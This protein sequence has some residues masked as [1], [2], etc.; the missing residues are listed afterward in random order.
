MRGFTVGFSASLAA[1]LWL[2][3]NLAVAVAV[4][5]WICLVIL[6]FLSKRH[7]WL[8]V[9]LCAGGALAHAIVYQQFKLQLPSDSVRTDLT[10]VGTV[11]SVP[12]HDARQTSFLFRIDEVLDPSVNSW[13]EQ[14]RLSWYGGQR[15]S[16][17]AGDRWQLL[18]RL[19]PSASLGNPGGFNFEQWLFYNKIH[20]TGY[21]RDS[22][23]PKQLNTNS[24]SLHAIRESLAK[25]IAQ[26]PSANEYAAL[27]QGLTVG[28]TS[29]ISIEQWQ[30]LRQSGTAHL[31]AISGLH[32][33]LVS[34]WF[35]FFA[36][37]VW[38]F[39]HIN[40]YLSRRQWCIKPVFS[41]TLSC[42]SA[43]AYAALAGFSLPTQ[44]ALIML[45]VFALTV[46]L[47]RIWPPGTAM[48]LALLAVLL[49]GPLAVLSVGF[50]LSF[51]T[52]AALFYLHNGRISRIGSKSSAIFVHLKLG[53]V[54]L[55]VTA[56]FF[57]QGSLVAPVANAIA[58]PLVGLLVVPVSLVIALITPL[59]SAGAN[60]LLSM[61]QW[62]LAKLL[63]LLDRML[64]L[65]ASHLPLFLPDS[66]VLLCALL[67]LLLLFSPRSLRLRWL[68]VPLLAPAVVL[69]VLGKPVRGIDLHVLDV[70]QGLSA[71]L[72]T[73]NHT[74]LFDTGK[75]ISEN[76]T[77]IDRVV[78]PFLISQGRSSIDIS[79][80][81]HADDDH[82][83]GVESL[84]AYY[85]DTRLFAG[86]K[87]QELGVN[88]EACIA[89][90]TFVFD[91]VTFTFIHPGASDMGS[92]NNMSCVL[93]V[94]YGNTRILLTGDIESESERLLVDRIGQQLP[95]TTLIAPHH[96]SRSSST[97]P[98]V[99]IF[100]ADVVVFA[101]GENNKF[102]FPHADVVAR[103]SRTG[104]KLFTT[105]EH[106]A[107]YLQ[108]DKNGLA[109]PVEWFWQN[110]RR[111]RR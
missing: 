2:G 43:A 67:S 93:L 28:V 103:Y 33:G 25:Q 71:V 107:L 51:G 35:Y 89:G 20:A 15:R 36:G 1:T 32:V 57:Q 29:G 110:R 14:V 10:V 44:R 94:H 79:V 109:A 83:G 27:I 47:R 45:A 102:K 13:P 37:F 105:G 82:A 78:R 40:P 48:V 46:V 56:W 16:L 108:Y 72:F 74:V 26:L 101:A 97:S 92:R 3:Q 9:G 52:V 12:K 96:G 106:G 30:T 54:L 8:V 95:L 73:E 77:M 63:H 81:S 100:P 88:A 98:F 80:V 24:I 53:V 69:N 22:P 39:C 41:L 4:L 49:M 104:A 5:P 84:L 31:L 86:D 75:R 23:Q 58:V 18:A 61:N 6:L 19:K 76:A 34:G 7:L 17:S 21:V 87:E 65:P 59:W 111:Y 64:D 85:P 50:W 38:R 66:L 90:K 62:V 99:S 60:A 55:P 68:A 91:D 42:V 70:G 11:I